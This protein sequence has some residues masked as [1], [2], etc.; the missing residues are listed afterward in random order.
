L[1]TLLFRLRHVPE[2]EAEEVRTLLEQ[3]DIEYYETSAGNWRISMPA[4]W[5]R[6]DDQL[7]LARQLL[8]QYQETRCRNAR[9]QYEQLRMSGGHRTLWQNFRE[10]PVKVALYLGAAVLVLYLSLHVF[11]SIG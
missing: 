9:S 11:L 7:E 6:N 5:I 10:E 4:I 8:D 1:A 3:H 2:D